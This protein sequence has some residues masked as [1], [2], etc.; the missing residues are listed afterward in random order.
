[1]GGLDEVFSHIEEDDSDEDDYMW[2]SLSTNIDLQTNLFSLDLR[3]F[4]LLITARVY[5][6]S[7]R[8]AFLEEC[9]CGK[10]WCMWHVG[11]KQN[12]L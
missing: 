10:R 11:K 2:R 5:D 12:E 6:E 8:Q 3:E 9:F 7:V 1:L 4:K